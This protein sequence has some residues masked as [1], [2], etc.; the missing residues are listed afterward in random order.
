M[1]SDWAPKIS[2]PGLQTIVDRALG[3]TR[4]TALQNYEDYDKAKSAR[5][6]SRLMTMTLGV[7]E[8]RMFQ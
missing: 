2:D 6:V 5:A 1:C 7:S 3:H 8:L 4:K